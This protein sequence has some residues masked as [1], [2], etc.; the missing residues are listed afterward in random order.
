MYRI[1]LFMSPGIG[2]PIKVVAG[3]ADKYAAAKACY[4]ANKDKPDGYQ[5]L[6][7]RDGEF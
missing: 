5:W 6:W 4:V 2:S 1:G 7:G 3:F